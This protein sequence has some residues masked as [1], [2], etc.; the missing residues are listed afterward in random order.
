MSYYF[1]NVPKL[2]KQVSHQM[3]MVELVEY[4]ISEGGKV[5][6][7]QCIAIVKNWWATMALKAVGPGYVT[8]TFFERGAHIKEGAPL[9]IIVCDPEDEPKDKETSDLEIIGNIRT[10][11]L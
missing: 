8:K 1:V 9:A 2:Q 3:G 11:P 5:E 7:G 6:K 10:K 4:Q